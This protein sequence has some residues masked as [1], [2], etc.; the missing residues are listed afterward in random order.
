MTSLAVDDMLG[1][2]APTRVD[3]PAREAPVGRGVC[4]GEAA[5]CASGGTASACGALG[6][7]G[8]GAP[9]SRLPPP[10]DQRDCWVI[11][12]AIYRV[13]LLPHVGRL[14]ANTKQVLEGVFTSS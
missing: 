10:R 2:R 8:R 6:P 3:P 13:W 4:R 12:W 1:R 7:G 5:P 14:R 11:S 9:P